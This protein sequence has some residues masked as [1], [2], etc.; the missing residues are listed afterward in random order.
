MYELYTRLDR[1]MFKAQQS[2]SQIF[3]KRT[4]ASIKMIRRLSI[5]VLANNS[6][7]KLRFPYIRRNKP[8]TEINFLDCIRLN[9]ELGSRTVVSEFNL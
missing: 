1:N 2:Y 7:I 9:L 8:I 6:F 4:K 3:P 5:P